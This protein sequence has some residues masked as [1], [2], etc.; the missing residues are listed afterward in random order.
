MGTHCRVLALVFLSLSVGLSTARAGDAPKTEE[1]L[2]A[3]LQLV[4]Q[5]IEESRTNLTA[6]GKI[7]WKQQHD[8]EYAD[9]ECAQLRDE[10]KALE[11]QVIEKRNQLN[12]RLKSKEPIR[13]IDD[14]RKAMVESL[15]ALLDKEKLILNELAA[16][17][18]QGA[19]KE[20]GGK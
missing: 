3:E 2:R 4:R 5:Q 16:A 20:E 10:I 8:L 7:L 1:S 11:S 14:Q 19:S 15:R 17:E 6:Q 9:P 13:A 12:A 18:N